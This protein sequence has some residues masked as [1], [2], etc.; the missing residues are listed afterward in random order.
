VAFHLSGVIYVAGCFSGSNIDFDPGPGEDLRSMHGK[1]WGD[2]YLSKFDYNGEYLWARTWGG[3]GP[4]AAYAVAVG[5]SQSA[6][7]TGYFDEEVDFDPGPGTDMH[8]CNGGGDTFLCKFLP[9]G[10]W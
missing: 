10:Y 7:V 4:D 9:D 6:Y 3:T 8:I 5:D 1:Y 2:T